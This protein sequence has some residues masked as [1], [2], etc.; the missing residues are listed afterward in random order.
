MCQNATCGDFASPCTAFLVLSQRWA[1]ETFTFLHHC[2]RCIQPRAATTTCFAA[3]SVSYIALRTVRSW[4]WLSFRQQRIMVGRRVA[5]VLYVLCVW[6]ALGPLALLILCSVRA[7]VHEIAFVVFVASSLLY[8]LLSLY[9]FD[10]SGRRRSFSK[11]CWIIQ[12][13]TIISVNIRFLPVFY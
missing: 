8:M 9:M 2:D 13:K 6:Y 3:L 7:D 12:K 11:V 4:L 1:I 10:H 5:N